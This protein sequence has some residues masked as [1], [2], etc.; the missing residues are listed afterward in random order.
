[1]R[2][3]LQQGG[4]CLPAYLE[5]AFQRHPPGIPPLEISLRPRGKTPA[6]FL[7]YKIP[8]F[9]IKLQ[10][11]RAGKGTAGE[12]REAPAAVGPPVAQTVR[13]FSAGRFRLLL[14]QPVHSSALRAACK[15]PAPPG[16]KAKT[17]PPGSSCEPPGG[18]G[19][20]AVNPD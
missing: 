19:R 6:C 20:S 12:G 8:K 13:Q 18:C 15:H 4:R 7:T 9:T 2:C 11:W 10:S 16:G 1:M 17:E 14:L 5:K 3:L